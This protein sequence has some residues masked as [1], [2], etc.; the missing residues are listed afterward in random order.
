[1]ADRKKKSSH[2]SSIWNLFSIIP[3]VYGL[4]LG[5]LHKMKLEA[6]FTIKQIVILG[7]LAMIMACAFTA[8]WIS[9]LGI[10]FFALLQWQWIWYNAALMVMLVNGV[11]LIILFILIKRTKD[12]IS[13]SEATR[14]IAR[15]D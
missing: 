11:C 5:M 12:K 6:F 2:F 4:V 8:T 13:F 10:L 1:M 9:L 7:F 3:N 15:R 14:N